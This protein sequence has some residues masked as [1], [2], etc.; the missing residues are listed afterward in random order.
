MRLGDFEV[1]SACTGKGP[2][3]IRLGR[4]ASKKQGQAVVPS[5]DIA[6][7]PEGGDFIGT[8]G[9]SHKR[10]SESVRRG[11][12]SPP[13]DL[14]TI[15]KGNGALSTEIGGEVETSREAGETEE[16]E[17]KE[18]EESETGSSVSD[19]S[20]LPGEEKTRRSLRKLLKRL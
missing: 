20:R 2:Q 12:R 17:T 10:C 9:M 6:T 13:D 15:A 18:E 4:K 5:A 7:P 11:G 19:R 16:E 3:H 8:V 1:T 14:A